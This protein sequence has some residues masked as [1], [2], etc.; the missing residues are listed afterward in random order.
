LKRDDKEIAELEAKLGLG[1]KKKG[2]F[3]LQMKELVS[4]L[5]SA[6]RSLKTV[7]ASFILVVI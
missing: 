4:K 7:R 3:N 2:K 5:K 1:K 6:L